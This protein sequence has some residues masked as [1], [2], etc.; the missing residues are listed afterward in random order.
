MQ[1]KLAD[2]R[3]PAPELSWDEID[4]VLEARQ[5]RPLWVRR[6]AAAAVLLL[7]AGAGYLAFHQKEAAPEQ[8]PVTVAHHP[9]QPEQQAKVVVQQTVAQVSSE[10]PRRATSRMM[11]PS[12]ESVS[13][14]TVA[15]VQAEVVAT[16]AAEEMD[17]PSVTESKTSPAVSRPKVVYPADL[18]RQPTRT[19]SRLMA[20]VYMSNT[21]GNS[22]RSE[23]SARP[24]IETIIKN[25]TV[26]VPS[27]NVEN[28][29][30]HGPDYENEGTPI[31]QSNGGDGVDSH[32]PHLIPL[33]VYD[34]ISTVKW[35]QT[36]HYVHHRQPVRFGLSLR[37]RI[38]DRWSVES[39]LS[40]TRLSSDITTLVDGVSTTEEQRLNYIGVPLNV[41]YQLWGNRRFSVYVL[42]G[43]IVE[44][45]LDASPW[46]FS[47]NGAAGVEY[48]FN[49]QFSI[50]AEPGFGYYFPDGSSIPTIYQDRRLN[51][52][53]GFGLRMN[54]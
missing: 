7:I 8:P 13:E 54:L 32:G 27:G 39:G 9:Q 6:V 2:Y 48:K 18:H 4:K 35:E 23:S 16:S 34:T 24:Y 1:Q 3:R 45:M 5:S 51:L 30:L 15:T 38:S 22:R 25:R 43:G 47:L 17:A 19:G 52:N 28:P 37:Y 29:G 20:K 14:D 41:G 49:R 50:Y 12:V 21:M 26:Y 31:D 46:Q 10:R 44:K 40:Y 42:A 36:D 11:E 33:T 53:L